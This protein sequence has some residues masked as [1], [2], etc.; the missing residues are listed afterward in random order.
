M[1]KLKTVTNMA[2]ERLSSGRKL[3][4]PTILFKMGTVLGKFTCV[5]KKLSIKGI[6]RTVPT[7]LKKALENPN[8]TFKKI[9]RG[10]LEL[11]L[12]SILLLVA[13]LF[14]SYSMGLNL[15]QR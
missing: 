1:I 13:S 5:P 15:T 9:K 3:N 8:T 11:Y 14:I 12:I 6:N 10:Y 2:K 7:P 4:I